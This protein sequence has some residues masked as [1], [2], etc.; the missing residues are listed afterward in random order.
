MKKNAIQLTILGAGYVGRALLQRFLAADTTRRRAVPQS[1]TYV[2][3]LQD[4]A[5]WGNPPLAGRTVVWTFPAEPLTLV[6]AFFAAHLRDV[7]G[8]IVLGSTSAYRAVDA[9][10]SPASTVT[11]QTP[12]DLAQPRVQGEE[13]LR[14]RGATVLQLAGIFGPGR[15][16]VGW[17]QRGLIKDGAKLVN[18]IHVD[19]IVAV[20]AH[21]LVQPLPGARIN[22]GNGEPLPWREL[23]ARFR[24]DGRLPADFVLPETGPQEFGKRIDNRLLCSLLPDHR[25]LRP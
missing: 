9:A 2:F 21:V 20:I 7:A 4:P 18:L 22:V 5:T 1:R 17:L 19:D 24:A 16:P 25:F 11:E 15:D 23:A 12:L 14:E 6:Q 10:G 13:W 3:N 8:L